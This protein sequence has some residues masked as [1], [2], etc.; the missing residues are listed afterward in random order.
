MSPEEKKRGTFLTV[1]LIL[2]LIANV[3][4]ALFY[5]ALSFTSDIY[6]LFAIISFFNVSF[7]VAL[8]RWDKWGFYGFCGSTV[9][10]FIINLILGAGLTSVL[11][12]VSIFILYIAMKPKWEYFK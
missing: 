11:G 1:W 8:F 7:T 3:A 9:V 6:T 10:T 2:I 12:F 5:A 4:I